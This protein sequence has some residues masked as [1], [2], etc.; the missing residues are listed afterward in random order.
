[1]ALVVQEGRMMSIVGR[2]DAAIGVIRTSKALGQGM[3]LSTNQL[4]RYI[5]IICKFPFLE[6]FLIF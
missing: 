6:F 1:M 4:Y 3:Q 2:C 5:L